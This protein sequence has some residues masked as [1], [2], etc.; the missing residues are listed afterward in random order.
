ML[1]QLTPALL[2]SAA[3]LAKSCQSQP[4]RQTAHSLAPAPAPQVLLQHHALASQAD[5]QGTTPLLAAVRECCPEILAELCRAPSAALGLN[6]PSS[7]TGLTA[8]HEAAG[9]QGGHELIRIMAQAGGEHLGCLPQCW[10][11]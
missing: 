1:Q 11:A 5:N 8:M 9:V 2:I 6:A 3:P 7:S 10:T 4:L